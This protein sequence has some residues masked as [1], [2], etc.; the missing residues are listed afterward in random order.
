MSL[1]EGKKVGVYEIVSLIGKG[2][3]GEVY[4]ARDPRLDRDVA[5]KV[6]SEPLMEQSQA[7]LRFEQEAKVLA[8]LSHPNILTVHDVVREQGSLY[9]VMELLKGETLRELLARGEVGWTRALQIATAITDGVAAAHFHGIIHRDLKPEN[10]FLT[11]HGQIKILDF[12]LARVEP[13]ATDKAESWMDTSPALSQPGFVM[14]TLRSMAPEQLRGLKVDARADIYS[15]GCILYEMVSGRVAFDGADVA[16]LTA[17]ILRD[18]PAPIEGGSTPKSLIDLIFHCLEKDP[19]MR[20]ES[21]AEVATALRSIPPNSPITIPVS[22]ARTRTRAKSVAIL[23]IGHGSDDPEDEFLMDGITESIINSISQLPKLKVTARSTAFRYKGKD[24]DPRKVGRDLG[25]KMLMMGRGKKRADRLEIQIELVNTE[26]GSQVWGQHF[27]KNLSDVFSVQE[28]IATLISTAI[29]KKLTGAEKKLL[30]KRYT[31]NVE[32]YQFYL[33]GRY[34]WNRRSSEAFEKAIGFFEKAIETDPTYALA[35]SGI[36]DC[37]NFLGWEAYG[38]GDPKVMFPRAIA[39]AG[40]ALE[41]D[42]SLSEAYNSL[43]WAKWAFNRDWDGAE[44]DYKRAIKLN[45]G[46]AIAHVWYADL[47]AGCGRL[48]EALTEIRI[49]ETLDPLASIAYSVHGLIL[50]YTRDYTQSLREIET[51][52]ELQAEFGPGPYL[53]ARVLAVQ[54]KHAEAIEVIE[55][56][57]SRPGAHPRLKAGLALAY[58][59]AGRNDDAKTI[60]MELDEYSKQNYQP[61]LMDGGLVYAFLGENETALEW[62]EKAYMEHAAVLVWLFPDPLA[63]PLRSDPRFDDLMRKIGINRS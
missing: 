29:Q 20:F 37:Y 6:L 8:S 45:P 52:I 5:I 1:Q 60:L 30:E 24:I 56:I 57:A 43:A 63:D 36:A 34:Y 7:L 28:E 26:D 55:P 14:G 12:G 53:K 59:A 58:V 2:G 16:E 18:V 15:L 48:D 32:A 51:A 4:R 3:M 31:Q 61:A 13:E 44:H 47:L 42:D 62:L 10:V 19:E 46:Y 17:A 40:K 22:A 49:A 25:V 23:P 38:T 9:V 54:G 27:S 21:A 35:Y 50:Y 33:K 11:E 41:I 39:A